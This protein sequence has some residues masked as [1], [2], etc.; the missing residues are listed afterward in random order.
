MQM[1]TR[2]IGALATRALALFVLIPSLASAVQPQFWKLTSP[3]DF[4]AGDIEGMAVTS[5]GELRP[6]PSVTKVATFTEP[7]VLSQAG[8]SKGTTYFG[9][10]NEGK[11]YSLRGSDRKLLYTA[12]EPEIYAVAFANGSLFVGSSPNGRVYRVNPTDGKA[13]EFFD[14]RSAYIWDIEPLSDGSLAIAT[15]VEGKLFRVT[16]EGKGSVWFDAPES[17]LRSIAATRNGK[18]LAGGSGEGR[19]YEVDASGSG[20]ALYDSPLTEISTIYYDR[21]R[22]AAWAAGVTN[23]PPSAPPPKPDPKA[24]PAAA[25]AT[26]TTADQQRKP[27]GS[28]TIDV[29]FSFDDSSN[30]PQT[31]A[32]AELYRIDSDGYVELVRKLDR[33]M[34]YAIGP[35]PDGAIILST[36]PLGRIYQ[37]KG[38]EI[39]LIATVPEKQVVS[40][41][42]D[43]TSTLATT[44]N[45]GAIYR[46][47]RGAASTSEYRSPIKDTGRFSSFGQFRVEGSEVPREGLTVAFRS[48][49][50]ATPD[51]TW[52]RWYEAPAASG[53]VA[54]PQARYLQWRIGLKNGS[55]DSSFDAMTVAFVNRNAAPIIENVGVNDPGVI[56][57]T[58]NYP[59]SPQVLEATNPDE[60]GI[61]T[62]LDTPRDRN[63]PG[64]KLF[65]KGY[66][67]LAWKASDPNGDT[68]R[69]AVSFRRKNDGNWLRL[70]ENIEESQINFDTSQLPDG[71]Y[72]VLLVASDAPDN[73]EAPLTDRREG[74]E[75]TVD[76]TSPVINVSTRGDE[77][78][79][80]IRDGLSPVGKV[81]YSIDAQKW[82]R[83]LPVD[84]IADST[85][86]QFTLKRSDVDGRFVIVRAVDSFANVATASVRG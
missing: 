18:V 33:E 75:F 44:T 77:F 69:Y 28:P 49:N 84:G 63:D 22:N 60:Y 36:G 20:R 32:S 79:I 40:F 53:P 50:T 48:G 12:P 45:S 82:V 9:T 19:I 27:E 58:G 76:N 16:P 5:S 35:G 21:V 29:S 64:K 11:V 71:V 55:P 74:A 26:T 41:A 78:V 86:E 85:D 3:E 34:I 47:S 42:A 4:L 46:L 37:Y 39:A 56:F 68:L 23:V 80:S 6:G 54:A 43:G 2:R 10:G 67:T 66:R 38:N 59:P 61:F 30:A 70:R 14:P 83:L 7:F 51:E 31:G 57:I 15:G 13:E 65:R 17:H 25:G 8:D 62:G 24:T 73:P 1:T 81:E 72:Q 52:S